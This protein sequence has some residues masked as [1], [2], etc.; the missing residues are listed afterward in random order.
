ME[1]VEDRNKYFRKY[2]QKFLK[3]SSENVAIEM[4]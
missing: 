4:F 3:S 1:T 2:K